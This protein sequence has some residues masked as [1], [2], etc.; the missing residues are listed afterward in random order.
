MPSTSKFPTQST[1]I[2]TLWAPAT[3]LF[4]DD[5]NYCTLSTGSTE[6][7]IIDLY[8]FGFGFTSDATINN[9]VIESEAY[10]S[11]NNFYDLDWDLLY[12]STIK[13]SGTFVSSGTTAITIYNSSDV[14]TWTAGELLV[15][16]TAGLIYRLKL[17]GQTA[18]NEAYVD[19]AKMT[20]NYVEPSVSPTTNFPTQSTDG[21]AGSIGWSLTTNFFADDGN[22]ALF[23]PESTNTRETFL[24]DFD[25]NIS[26]DAT[27]DKIEI[28]TEYYASLSNAISFRFS[29]RY[30]STTLGVVTTLVDSTT[31]QTLTTTGSSGLGTWTPD[32]LNT[33][34]T[35]GV[36]LR[37]LALGI[38][39][40]EMLL[41]MDYVKLIVTFST[42][43]A[44]STTLKALTANCSISPSNVRQVGRN[45]TGN[46][47]AS[48]SIERLIGK[49]TTASVDISNLIPRLMGITKTSN[50]TASG[51][52]I[53]KV[54]KNLTANISILASMARALIYGKTLTANIS[55]SPSVV[56]SILRNVVAN[57]STSPTILRD[58]FK[59]MTANVSA[60]PT[61]VRLTS[62]ILSASN[63]IS[64]SMVRSNVFFKTL[65]ANI[66]VSP[67][68]VRQMLRNI[69]AN[70]SLSGTRKADISK[71]MQANTN[72][73]PSIVRSVG[74]ILTASVTI[75]SSILRKILKIIT[76]TVSILASMT[77]NIV[78]GGTTYY[79]TLTANVTIGGSVTRLKKL[80]GY[81]WN[82]PKGGPLHQKKNLSRHLRSRRRK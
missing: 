69:T 37:I 4:A 24:Y 9:I 74:K 80:A 70:V 47:S 76:A 40:T 58:M 68:V 22:Y 32:M 51:S 34:S 29:L 56:R 31:P 35:A 78:S 42:G 77:R 17:R 33:N 2:S 72:I 41:Y 55:I 66:T 60:S 38:T 81:I 75:D 57:V 48:P 6:F 18:R 46:V 45:I 1:T 8:N 73:T 7:Q 63:T 20:V 39:S 14:G 61:V 26:T 52:V 53:R 11:V 16:T 79:K 59:T 30:N 65:T 13:A 19:Y 44:G 64:A 28:A 50:S 71:T 67:T 25:F 27:I 36:L 54:L 3:N 12:N 49:T 21:G 10:A 5:G 82:I 23:D 43:A 62:K 15:N